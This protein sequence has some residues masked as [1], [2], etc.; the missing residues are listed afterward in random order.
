[1]EKK[2]SLGQHFL[3]SAHYLAKIVDAAKLAEG[4][5]VLE[6]G[7]GEGVLTR[8]LLARGVSVVAIEKDRRLVPVLQKTFA[9]EI[10]GGSLTL[11]EEDILQFDI[12]NCAALSG[13]YKVV[14]NIPY[15]LTGALLKKLLTGTRQPML[16]VLL[17][18]KEVA[19]RIVRSKKESILS[20]SVKAYGDPAYV[21]TVPQGAFTPPPKVNSAI[22][23]VYDISYKRFKNKKQERR[24]FELVR[25]GFAQKRKLLARNLEPLLGKNYSRI[26]QNTRIP[27]KARAEDVPLAQWL[28]L[29]AQ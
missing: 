7:P 11:I 6:V 24:F 13:R 12:S 4:E 10:A 28:T 9:K 3:H 26:L 19:E 25:A 5:R 15:Y 8:E 2:K 1:M 14:A 21:C 27:E 23:G 20:L 29:S 17:L 16:M 22:L 18:Q